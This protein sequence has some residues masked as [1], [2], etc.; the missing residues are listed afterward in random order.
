MDRTMLGFT[1]REARVD[2]TLIPREE[3]ETF[4]A[5]VLSET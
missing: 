2:M 1:G 5:L 3:G 4:V